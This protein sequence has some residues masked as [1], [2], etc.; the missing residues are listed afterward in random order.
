M[1]L[2]TYDGADP[3]NVGS[4]GEI[5]ILD[6]AEQVRTAVGFEGVIEWDRSK[7]NGQPRRKLDHSRAKE[8]FGFRA[9]TSFED[10]LRETIS[11]YRSHAA[12][13]EGTG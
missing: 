8:R 6:L 11:W 1:A 3:V 2:E 7:P 12:A 9:E 10:G 4:G 13:S 5:S